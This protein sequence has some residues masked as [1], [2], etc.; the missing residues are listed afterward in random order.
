MST[1]SIRR[2]L[3]VAG[4]LGALLIWAARHNVVHGAPTGLPA[5]GPTGL[6][7]IAPGTLVMPGTITS[8]G[9]ALRVGE[10]SANT[11]DPSVTGLSR[12]VGSQLT[13]R[14]GTLAW[15]KYGTGNTAWGP[16]SSFTT[17]LSL[18]TARFLGRITAGTGAPEQLTGTQATTLLD[19]F[20][21]GLKGL[22]PA[23]GGGT[24]N[25]LR[26]DGTFAA[27]GAGSVTFSGARAH[28][29]GTQGVATGSVGGSC[30]TSVAAGFGTEDFDVGSYHDNVT[31]NSRFT[32]PATGK[33]LIVG[34]L[35][36][37]GNATGSRW[38]S[39]KVNGSGAVDLASAQ[40][41]GASGGL[42]L[43]G[44][45]TLSLTSGDFVEFFACHDAGSSLN[46]NS[47]TF[48]AITSIGG[49]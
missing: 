11:F 34:M 30:A 23:S 6:A 39:Y 27:P 5:S 41:I 1:T 19:V 40:N 38:L 31:N 13:S 15:W 7:A 25:F 21:S 35:N 48:G 12:P 16:N 20:T 44:S 24:T 22:V 17:L 10:A 46:L 45:A 32:V 18:S 47:A 3:F 37:A 26:A 4:I 43:N 14:D 9:Q 49:P 2:L 29:S 28:L 8:V 42:L 33:Y 36:W